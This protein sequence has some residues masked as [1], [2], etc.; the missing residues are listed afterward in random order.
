MIISG[1]LR[2]LFHFLHG[3][4]AICAFTAITMNWPFII[5]M[6]FILANLFFIIT[7]NAKKKI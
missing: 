6:I 7:L 4:V 3:I 2:I 5:L 1:K